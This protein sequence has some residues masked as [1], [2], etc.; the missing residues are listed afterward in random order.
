MVA[1]QA[2][3]FL[4]IPLLSRLYTP[5]DFADFG[6]F[7]ALSSIAAV[8]VT[9]RY[10]AV[11]QLPK[12]DGE[13]GAVL[14]ACIV[15]A[16]GG[17]L[18]LMALASATP[19]EALVPEEYARLK[20]WLVIA[21]GAG[22]VSACLNG[23]YAMLNRRQRFEAIASLRVLQAF[24]ISA[25]AIIFGMWRLE[26]GLL[27][28]QVLAISVMAALC[29]REI[30]KLDVSFG[31]HDVIAAV[32]KHRSAPKFLLP[33][34]LLD[35]V[36]QQLPLLLI[37]ALFDANLAGQFSMAWRV[38]ALPTAVVGAAVGQVFY[39]RFAALWPDAAA[40]RRLV[41]RS[42]THL[43]ALGLLPSLVVVLFG[44]TLFEVVLG[45]Q[46]SEAGALAGLLSPMLLA[47]FVSSATS[48]AYIVL[49]LERQTLFFSAAF[50]I[51][52]SAAMI[53]GAYYESIL[54][55]IVC[56][57]VCEIVAILIYNLIMLRVMRRYEVD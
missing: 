42:W 41:I 19:W 10:D 31:R 29:W 50:L 33:A 46:W 20:S 54:V 43:F 3:N 37:V 4:A 27:F 36:T 44:T 24:C 28:A 57:S 1:A 6:V 47:M 7:I 48:S 15:L 5:V 51:Y 12:S 2:I 55:S 32:R 17:G 39:Q 23:L 14:A 22:S 34:A 38:M 35:V 13:S 56:W 49:G 9:L 52:R 45:P 18:I 11:I 30:A 53:V 21:L 26:S 25:A 8:A 16:F 40:G